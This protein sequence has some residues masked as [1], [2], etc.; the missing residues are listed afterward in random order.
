MDDKALSAATDTPLGLTPEILSKLESYEDYLSFYIQLDQA[1]SA[2]AWLKA[3]LLYQMATKLGA[4]SIEQLARDIKQPR[5]TVINYVRT[6]KAFPKEARSEEA[7]F[8]IHF[9]ASFADS[10]DEKK[11]EFEGD[12]RFTW[13]EKAIDEG[14][15]TRTLGD[16]IQREKQ[17]KLLDIP[18]LPCT[19]CGKTDGEIHPY[20][21][22]SPGAHKPGE[23]FELHDTCYA[24]LMLFIYGKYEN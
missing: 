6:A 11:G 20:L 13:V 2:F 21:L 17:R 23:R 10:Y 3:D 12:T 19:R 18:T 1:S 7:S 14:M 24:D 8:S 4:T 16:A 5:S 9:R 15:S 22:Y